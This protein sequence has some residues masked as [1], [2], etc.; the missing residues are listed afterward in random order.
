MKS[1]KINSYTQRVLSSG[2]RVNTFHNFVKNA[3]F[4]FLFFKKISSQ[5]QQCNLCDLSR[6][7]YSHTTLVATT[8]YEI[9]Q[10][11]ISNLLYLTWNILMQNIQNN[12]GLI[13]TAAHEK[14]SKYMCKKGAGMKTQLTVAWLDW[15]HQR[16]YT[17]K[18]YIFH[19]V[20]WSLR[21]TK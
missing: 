5:P 9:W 15:A 18:G 12:H 7:Y 1:Y 17:V 19:T 6:T 16:A 13:K 8:V 21:K 10:F 20:I 14:D 2:Y 4:F 3:T 11:G